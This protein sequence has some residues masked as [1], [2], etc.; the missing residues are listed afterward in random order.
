MSLPRFLPALIWGILWLGIVGDTRIGSASADPEPAKPTEPPPLS[1][2]EALRHFK[3]PEDLRLDLVLHEPTVRQPVQLSFDERG[4]L[5]VVQ[6]IQYPYPAGLKMLSRDGVWRVVYDQ[7]P[8]PPPRH[9]RG[10]DRITIHEDADGDGTYET[11]KVFVEG[12]NL[13]TAAARG[14][15]GVWVLNPPYLLFYPDRDSDDV[16][17]GDPEVHLSGFGLEDSHSVVN[18]LCWGPDGWLYAAQGS[19]VSASVRK[20]GSK[21]PPVTSMGQLIWRYHPEKRRYEIFAEGGGNAF[22]VEID[23]LGRV[24]SGH[25]GGD[26]RGFH[27]VQGGYYLK[28]FAKHGPLSNPFAFGY[29]GAMRHNTTP[30]FTHTFAFYDGTGL[31]DRYRD[32]LF[33]VSPVLRH[34]VMSERKPDGSTFQTHD[35]GFAVTTNDP[36][37]MPVDIKHGPDGALYIADWYDNRAAHGQHYEGNIH[38][39]SGRVYRLTGRETRPTKV[40]DLGQLRTEE[41]VRLLGHANRWHRQTALRLLGDRKDAAAIPLCEQLL[42]SDDELTALGGLWGLYQSGGW[43]EARGVELLRHRHS[44]VR[45]W[46][47]RLLC[48][49][50]RINDE[51]ASHLA[52][53]AVAERE[54]VVRSQLACSAR[55]LPTP[56]ALPVIRALLAHDE[57]RT[58]PHIPLLLWWALE[59][60]ITQNPQEVLALFETSE[61]WNRPLVQE[62][63]LERL[64]RRF[65]ATGTRKDLDCCARLL[66]LSPGPVATRHLLAGFEAAFL[67]RTLPDLPRELAD[68]LAAYGKHSVVLGLRQKR[69]EAVEEALRLISDERGERSKQLQYV[70]VLGETAPP[71]ALPTLLK[72]ATSSPDTALRSAALTSLQ[73][74][75][76]PIIGSAILQAL[77]QMSD[78]LRGPALNLLGSRPAW[79]RSVIDAV[80]AG[81]LEKRLVPIEF[82][83]RMLLT[84]DEALHDRI[85]RVWGDLEPAAPQALR[86][87]LERLQTVVHNGSGV[88]KHGRELF[89]QQCGKCHT[90]FGEGGKVGPDLTSYNRNDLSALLLNIVHPNAEIREGYV[91][92][93]ILTKDGRTLVGCLA[94]QDAGAVVLRSDEGSEVVVARD[95]IEVMETRKTSLMPEGLLKGLTEQQVRDLVAYLRISQPL[96]DK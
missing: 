24:F 67:G 74:Y 16:P 19:T 51:T 17:D 44:Q 4:R 28:G 13:T 85:R 83:R 25:N 3:T 55:R 11:H 37:F 68:A 40:P 14:R 63:M 41:L 70:Q 29:F 58:D 46:A 36:W 21:E 76:D 80:E 81:R 94:D 56:Q 75:D 87:E 42:R 34:V 27:Y 47:V 50:G 66:Q 89:R 71:Q 2:Q 7:V 59:A 45:A 6:Y 69:P 61:I 90:F 95:D 88:P 12:L 86:L 39:D 1:P 93:V 79:A 91:T 49:E 35:I 10:A 64:M 52:Q 32:V 96:I 38:R 43:T 23:H 82:A 77:P 65:A 48:D 78:D 8:P 5:W 33:G 73:R 53:L 26:T 92:Y 72:L 54:V 15:G 62:H 60:K 9:F 22:G 30:R 20:P 18:S 31:P 84:R 57:D